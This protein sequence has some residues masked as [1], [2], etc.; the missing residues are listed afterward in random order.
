MLIDLVALNIIDVVGYIKILIVM[1]P[2]RVTMQTM[3]V[4]HTFSS[5]N[6]FRSS[7]REQVLLKR[8]IDDVAFFSPRCGLHVTSSHLWLSEHSLNKV[9]A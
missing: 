2:T 9:E 7:Q 5:G 1:R 8:T 4:E 3:V 6:W